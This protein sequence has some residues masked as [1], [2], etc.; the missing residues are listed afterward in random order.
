MRYRFGI[1]TLAAAALLFCGCGS[2]SELPDG[3]RSF[4]P[5]YYLG[6][7][8]PEM[9]DTSHIAEAYK[10][11]DCSELSELEK[12]ILDKAS[13]VA[14]EILTPDMSDYE[15]ELAVH[16]YIVCNCA[17]DTGALAVIPVVGEHSKDPYGVLC[18]SKAI[19]EGYSCTFR[20]FMEMLDIPCETVY[21]IDDQN[22]D[23]AWNIVTLDGAPYYVDVTWDDP[24]PNKEDR[25]VYH[26]YFN[27]SADFMRIEHT[28]PNACPDTSVFT[29]SYTQHTLIPEKVS[30]YDLSPLV[31]AV[32]ASLENGVNSV[33][34]LPDSIGDWERRLTYYD[35]ASYKADDEL[36]R[37]IASICQRAGCRSTGRIVKADTDFGTALCLI[38]VK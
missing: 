37:E 34:F 4:T 11:G 20:M 27:V 5:E 31:G 10:S 3:S 18:E 1:T 8:P 35:D 12:S 9:F 14:E 16:D 23:H 6:I 38:L 25:L 19:C 28:L 29:E 30:T 13:A 33:C 2:S 7:T 22:R 17:Y 15:K 36:S 26:K 32:K 21:S 24:I